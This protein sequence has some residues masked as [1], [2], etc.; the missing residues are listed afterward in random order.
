MAHR[1]SFPWTLCLSMSDQ[2]QHHEDACALLVLSCLALADA[3]RD[4][5][6]LEGTACYP[7]T[8]FTR[9]MTV[10]QEDSAGRPAPLHTPIIVVNFSAHIN[11]TNSSEMNIKQFYSLEASYLLHPAGDHKLLNVSEFLELNE[12][13]SRANCLFW[14]CVCLL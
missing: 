9:S 2:E 6:G 11:N 10:Q 1:S 8:G 14:L 7:C 5:G 3:E 4:L 13:Q 12:L